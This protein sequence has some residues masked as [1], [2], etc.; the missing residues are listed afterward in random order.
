MQQKNVFNQFQQFLKETDGEFHIL[1]K[2]IPVEV[3]FEYFK[4]SD[5][6][7]KAS[8]SVDEND[9]DQFIADLNNPESTD[10]YKRKILSTLA[11]SRQVRAYRILEQYVKKPD[12][13]LTDWAY[14][15]LMESRMTLETELSDE[16][17]IYISTGLG[18]KGQKLRFFT[19]LLSAAKEPFLDYQQRVIERE[20]E[21]ALTRQNCEIERLTIKERH[22][23]MLLLMP[24]RLDIK[25]AMEDIIQE[26]NQYGNFLSGMFTVTNMKELGEEEIAEIVSSHIQKLS[27][28]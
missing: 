23:E 10:E 16:K 11:T 19:I 20:F 7:R 5:R 12:P 2:Q 21:Y 4:F 27:K 18:G 25:K 15:A 13:E 9:L 8:P 1:E 26:C 22:V 6:I 14:M 24:I 28:D 17:Q 3:Q